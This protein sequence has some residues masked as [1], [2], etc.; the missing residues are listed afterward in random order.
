MIFD[1]TIIEEPFSKVDGYNCYHYD[2]SKGRNVKGIDI[3][4]CLYHSESE[5][6]YVQIPINDHLVAKTLH[7][8]EIGT[9]KE[10]R[11]DM[12]GQIVRNQL[13]FR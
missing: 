3:L 13:P 7:Y 5:K 11:R 10:K 4:N 12:V 6:G 9:K 1:D 2:H 8:C